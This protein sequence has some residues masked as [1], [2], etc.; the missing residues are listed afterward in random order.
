MIVR[1]DSRS[2]VVSKISSEFL[3]LG[4]GREDDCGQSKSHKIQVTNHRLR[5]SSVLKDGCEREVLSEKKHLRTKD[6]DDSSMPSTK[7]Y[8]K[9]FYLIL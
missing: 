2:A 6:R 3:L 4:D 5:S 9:A 7:K 1:I 8:F